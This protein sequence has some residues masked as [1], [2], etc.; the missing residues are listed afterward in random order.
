MRGRVCGFSMDTSIARCECEYN[1]EHINYG[2][3]CVTRYCAAYVEATRVS[4]VIVSVAHRMIVRGSSRED[5]IIEY[6]VDNII[7]GRARR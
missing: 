7:N 2:V 1:I 3:F 5:V 4:E 6:A